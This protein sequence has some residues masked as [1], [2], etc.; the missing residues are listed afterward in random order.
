MSV[1]GRAVMF[2]VSGVFTYTIGTAGSNVNLRPLL[3]SAGWDQSSPVVV[4]INANQTGSTA[5]YVT[6]NFPGGLTL[7]NNAVIWGEGGAGGAGGWSYHVGGVLSASAN[8]NSG[9]SGGSGL[10]ITGYTGGSIKVVNNGVFASGGGG[11]GGGNGSTNTAADYSSFTGGQ[12]GQ[13]GT[14]FSAPTAGSPGQPW[15]GDGGYGGAHNS[16]IAA[17]G[18]QN[19]TGIDWTLAGSGNGCGVAVHGYSLISWSGSGSI[20]GP[21]SG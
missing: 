11:G 12:G 18:T 8:G 7:I 17:N 3:V 21:T 5:L 10:F 19:Q 2:L 14:Y 16:G 4:T 13:G 20:S 9:S 6:G 1:I 15:A